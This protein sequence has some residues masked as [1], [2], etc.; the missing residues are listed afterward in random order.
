MVPGDEADHDPQSFHEGLPDTGRELRTMVKHNVLWDTVVPEDVREESLCGLQGRRE[1]R[2]RS[3]A[4]GFGKPVHNNQGGDVSL[5]GGK[6]CDKVH[7]DMGPESLRNRQWVEFAIGEVSRC[8]ALCTGGAGSDV[9]PD[10]PDQGGP[11]VLGR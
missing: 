10:V 8:L 4:T 5:R 11:P 3:Q 7:G 2:Q 6:V 9:N 1:T